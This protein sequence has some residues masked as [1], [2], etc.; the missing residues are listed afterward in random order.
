MHSPESAL[1]VS[2]SLNVVDARLDEAMRRCRPLVASLGPGGLTAARTDPDGAR[3]GVNVD[4]TLIPSFPS[5]SGK[6][7]VRELA[8]PMLRRFQW[9]R[10]DLDVGESARGYPTGFA[11]GRERPSGGLT[12]LC[13]SVIAVADSASDRLDPPEGLTSEESVAAVWRQIPRLPILAGEDDLV[14]RVHAQLTAPD[15]ETALARCRPLFGRADAW[16]FDLRPLAVEGGG[17]WGVSMLLVQ[18]PTGVS[19][20]AL[21]GPAVH[22]LAAEYGMPAEHLHIHPVGSWSVGVLETIRPP[23]AAPTVHALY[24]RTGADPFSPRPADQPVETRELVLRGVVEGG[25]TR[26]S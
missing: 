10:G 11:A 21:V 17:V 22:A 26:P 6:A 8:A 1:I 18:R 5:A 19:P 20:Q 25:R 12:P 9:G 3:S 7:A 4:L 14:V 2:V 16:S 15:F 24:A 23:T 13:V